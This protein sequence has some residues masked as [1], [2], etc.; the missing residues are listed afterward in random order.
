[1]VN[2]D[3]PAAI[4]VEDS[5]TV[6]YQRLPTDA[7]AAGN[8]LSWSPRGSSLASRVVFMH[9]NIDLLAIY[10]MFPYLLESLDTI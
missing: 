10:N 5:P 4:A 9:D 8:R 3:R 7:Y 6:I 1:M 2:S